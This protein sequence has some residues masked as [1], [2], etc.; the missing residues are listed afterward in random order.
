MATLLD[1]LR[2]W[3]R[4]NVS[5]QFEPLSATRLV[6]LWIRAIHFYKAYHPF[7]T[8]LDKVANPCSPQHAKGLP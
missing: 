7:S 2:K 1:Q 6:R 4:R 3:A 8:R 5:Q